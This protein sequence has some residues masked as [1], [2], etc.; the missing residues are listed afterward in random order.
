MKK[1]TIQ[2][3]SDSGHAWAKVELKEIYELG[4]LGEIS[5]CSYVRQQKLTSGLKIYA[6]LEEDCDLNLYVEALKRKN[7]DI[8]ISFKESFTKGHRRSKI[9]SYDRYDAER[10]VNL[11]NVAINALK[12]F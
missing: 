9:R 11:M 7:P 1:K 4:L 12:R 6:Y 3:Y 10:Y 8:I 2:V 5:S